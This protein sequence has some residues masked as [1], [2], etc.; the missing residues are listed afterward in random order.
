MNYRDEVQLVLRLMMNEGVTRF[1][2]D[3]T[4][5]DRDFDY[6]VEWANN[7]DEAQVYYNDP[8]ANGRLRWVLLVLGNSTGELICDYGCN[9]DGSESLMDRVCK[10]YTEAVEEYNAAKAVVEQ[11]GE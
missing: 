10:K 1:E 2:D 8:E 11:Y 7:L 6:M 3:A 9:A 5:E 4:N